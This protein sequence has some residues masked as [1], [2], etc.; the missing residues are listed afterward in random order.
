MSHPLICATPHPMSCV[1]LAMSTS[2]PMRICGSAE[3]IPGANTL[4]LRAMSSWMVT[5]Y[6][7][8]G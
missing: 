5:V 7:V 4:P 6:S 2:S 3:T 1:L 8:V